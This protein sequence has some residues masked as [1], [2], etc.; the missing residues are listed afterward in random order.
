MILLLYTLQYCTQRA[1]DIVLHIVVD[2][3]G[4]L[5]S[6]PIIFADHALS[7]LPQGPN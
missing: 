4:G 5:L 2:P 1:I 7:N 3:P 6:R